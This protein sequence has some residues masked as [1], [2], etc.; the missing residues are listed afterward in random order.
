MAY[1]LDKLPSQLDPMA[2]VAEDAI[3]ITLDES[4]QTKALKSIYPWIEQTTPGPASR[5][6]CLAYL[7]HGLD[8]RER[9]ELPAAVA[10]ALRRGHSFDGPADP[11]CKSDLIVEVWAPMK[12]AGSECAC[13]DVTC[14][15]AYELLGSAGASGLPRYAI[16][17]WFWDH[18]HYFLGGSEFAAS[19]TKL[20]ALWIMPIDGEG[21]VN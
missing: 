11:K 8:D 12:C 21:W 3:A 10:T 18:N 14:R 2:T 15:L 20:K 13:H 9:S 19:T 17:V 5:G 1:A 6:V 7:P 4:L 16:F